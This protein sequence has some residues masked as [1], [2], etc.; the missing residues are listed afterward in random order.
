L[1]YSG[2]E[3]LLFTD[4][5]SRSASGFAGDT[6]GG[7]LVHDAADSG[8]SARATMI[9]VSDTF[10][11]N[12]V[13]TIFLM[14]TKHQAS[15]ASSTAC[16]EQVRTPPRRNLCHTMLG[17]H[18]DFTKGEGT[19]YDHERQPQHIAGEQQR[20]SKLEYEVSVEKSRGCRG[21]QLARIAAEV[22]SG[23]AGSGQ[24]AHEVSRRGCRVRAAR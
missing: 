1:A 19:M 11:F 4:L 24:G 5:L 13:E 17:L 22:L 23:P 9:T 20:P 16:T 8:M 21:R 14:I 10:Q 2:D 7:S 3:L 15:T 18:V 12:Q 6:L